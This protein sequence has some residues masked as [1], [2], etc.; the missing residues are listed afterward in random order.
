MELIYARWMSGCTRA[1]L[2]M[3]T[4]AF[5]AYLSGLAEPLIAFAELPQLWRLPLEA[6]LA[7]SGAPT[8]W[9]WMRVASHGDYASLAGIAVLGL[10][11]VVCYLRLLAA[12]L[13]RRERALALVAALQVALLLAAASGLLTGGH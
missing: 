8:G 1:G 11:S 2:A 3:L 4:A 5:L 9:D 6:Y 12:L 7:A 10:A 13:R